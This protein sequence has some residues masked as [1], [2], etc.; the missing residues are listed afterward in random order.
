MKPQSQE[1]RKRADADASTLLLKPD[2][3]AEQERG[4]FVVDDGVCRYLHFSNAY[5]QSQMSNDDPF[6]LDLGYTRMMMAFLLFLPRPR[7]IAIVGLG[8]GSLTKFCYRQLPRS[9]ITT[10]E[11][12]RQVIEFAD[13]FHIPEQDE[14]MRIVHADAVDFF[15]KGRD[16]FDV[17]LL[18]GCNERGIA[19]SFADLRFY[20]NL[21]ARL[22]PKGMLVSNMVGSEDDVAE[23]RA[24]ID[25]AFGGRRIELRLAR[26]GTRI[27]Y[28]FNDAGIAFDW[29]AIRARAKNLATA[30]PLDFAAFARQL[31]RGHRQNPASGHNQTPSRTARETDPT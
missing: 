25:R 8:G 22:R 26:E 16:R 1:S 24:Y 19:P 2:D 30:H 27:G 28:A 29:P 20:D 6:A 31:E 5:V 13:F 12:D 10:V 17:I 7:D 21:Q 23:H 3:D 9:R 18:D 11:I 4:A 14:R 15:A